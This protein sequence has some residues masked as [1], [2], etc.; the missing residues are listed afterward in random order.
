VIIERTTMT[1]AVAT[2]VIR[3]AE[4]CGDNTTHAAGITANVSPSI[5]KA[6]P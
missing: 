5:P 1:A 4:L 6:R 3:A 2:S